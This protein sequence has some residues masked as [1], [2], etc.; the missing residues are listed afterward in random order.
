[1]IKMYKDGKEVEIH[2]AVDVFEWEKQ[3]WSKTPPKPKSKND[4]L[5]N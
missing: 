3:G 4:K 5:P 1:M 2:H